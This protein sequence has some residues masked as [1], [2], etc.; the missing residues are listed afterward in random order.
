MPDAP[1]DFEGAEDRDWWAE[2]RF[3]GAFAARS[4]FP[5]PAGT[6]ASSRRRT[7]AGSLWRGYDSALYAVK[8][9]LVATPL[10]RPE[11]V[12]E[13]VRRSLNAL[14]AWQRL[15]TDGAPVFPVST[16]EEDG[17]PTV[18]HE[19]E[20]LEAALKSCDSAN[21]PPQKRSV[22]WCPI[23]EVALALDMSVA[24]S[25]QGEAAVGPAADHGPIG[26]VAQ[27]LDEAADSLLQQVTALAA[28]NSDLRRQLS[29]EREA[30]RQLED[31]IRVLYDKIPRA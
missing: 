26:H 3:V 2:G 16:F 23:D 29:E 24:A 7:P 27:A 21:Y 22:P 19:M 31:A 15:A 5:S 12:L 1:G 8:P 14:P 9:S 25:Q 13:G 11:A 18:E 20:W 28:E 30:R 17:E 4:S 10:A 6:N